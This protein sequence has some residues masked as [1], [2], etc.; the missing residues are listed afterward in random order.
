MVIPSRMVALSLSISLPLKKLKG[1]LLSEHR[2]LTDGETLFVLTEDKK[3][4]IDA[5]K[6]G[7]P[8]CVFI[9]RSFRPWQSL[10]K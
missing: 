3:V 4:I 2:F 1:W 7:Q 6:S 8:V 9:A 5:L 10:Q